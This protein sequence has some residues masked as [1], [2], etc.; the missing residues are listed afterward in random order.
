[1]SAH[2]SLVAQPR[3]ILE[4]WPCAIP[5]PSKETA[6]SNCEGGFPPPSSTEAFIAGTKRRQSIQCVE[7]LPPIEKIRTRFLARLSGRV[8]CYKMMYCQLDPRLTL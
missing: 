2:S 7:H 1:M 6:I 4:E 5:D 3:T 8:V